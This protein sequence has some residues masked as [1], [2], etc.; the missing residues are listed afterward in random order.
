MLALS[1]SLGVEEVQGHSLDLVS[2]GLI[3][4]T[5]ELS[6]TAEVEMIKEYN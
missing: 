1:L 5:E 2:S 3:N 4:N 6:Q